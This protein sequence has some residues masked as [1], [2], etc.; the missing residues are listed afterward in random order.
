MRH[1]IVSETDSL[2]KRRPDEIVSGGEKLHQT[3]PEPP[4]T[5]YFPIALGVVPAGCG[6][7]RASGVE[8]SGQKFGRKFRGGVSVNDVGHTATKENLI[9]QARCEGVRVTGGEGNL[10]DSLGEAVY[11]SEGFG[12]ACRSGSLSLKVHSVAGSGFVGAVSCEHA[13]S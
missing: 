8:K 9:E 5:F 4:P 6:A 11:D 7:C 2:C 3:V 10:R 1:R 12:F 13:M